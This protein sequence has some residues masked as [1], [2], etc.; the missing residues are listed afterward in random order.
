MSSHKLSYHAV[1]RSHSQCDLYNS[2][3]PYLTKQHEQVNSNYQL[4]YFAFWSCLEMNH[5]KLQ[6]TC[7]PTFWSA[8]LKTFH[9]LDTNPATKTMPLWRIHMYSKFIV[10]LKKHLDMWN[11]AIIFLWSTSIPET[12]GYSTWWIFLLTQKIHTLQS[13]FWIDEYFISNKVHKPQLGNYDQ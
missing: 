1:F 5:F 6:S 2:A 8:S 3:S 7:Q 10:G 9:Q 12:M 4:Y 13:M 11:I